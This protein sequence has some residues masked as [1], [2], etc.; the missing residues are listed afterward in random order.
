MT[1][2]D[3]APPPPPSRD[4]REDDATIAAFKVERFQR[5]VSSCANMEAARVVAVSV[6]VAVAICSGAVTMLA[7]PGDSHSDYHLLVRNGR[8]TDCV[9][10]CVCV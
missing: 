1:E 2:L 3:T 8:R 7:L 10:V 6:A 4:F 5:A 9:C